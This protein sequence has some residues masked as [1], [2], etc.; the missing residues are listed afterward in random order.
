MNEAKIMDN[1][2]DVIHLACLT[3][4]K[5]LVEILIAIK[6]S[7]EE[8]ETCLLTTLHGR[9]AFLE[10]GRKASRIELLPSEWISAFEELI[11]N[12]RNH[13]SHSS[14]EDEDETHAII[15]T[16][17]LLNITLKEIHPRS[18]RTRLSLA[19]ERMAKCSSTDDP[20]SL[21][22][23][24][25]SALVKASVEE[26]NVG[27]QT[28]V[29]SMLLQTLPSDS[30]A[31]INALA[32]VQLPILQRLD[33]SV[34]ET[35]L[36][37]NQVDYRLAELFK[38]GGKANN[39]PSTSLVEI[40]RIIRCT[41]AAEL[42]RQGKQIGE[43][44]GCVI[45]VPNEVIRENKHLLKIVKDRQELHHTNCPAGNTS[46][47]YDFVIGRGW[48]HNFVLNGKGG[49]KRMIHSEVHAVA[50]SIRIFGEDLAFDHLFPHAT[51][52]IV[53][54]KGDSAYDNAPPCPKCDTLLRAVGVCRACHTTDRGVVQNYQLA[55]PSLN[56]LDRDTVKIPLR[57]VCDEIGI[58][59]FRL[60]T[61]E[62]RSARRR[63]D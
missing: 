20:Y 33:V 44:H 6:S 48:N 42:A 37:C 57:A 53:E 11:A 2:G 34:L 52:V 12:K 28:E 32:A 56:F 27:L 1:L 22:V 24:Q 36:R 49:K 30:D 41:E 59:C 40:L 7:G 17:H 14:Q 58:E 15:N 9:K 60:R 25:A 50:D 16:G 47:S 3:N 63:A 21:S 5:L 46:T 43:K 13:S 39:T 61:A 38:Y 45:C 55:T 54:L 10:I 35:I 4:K 31:C 19:I 29:M 51:A 18:H 8:A 23:R 26:V 62:E